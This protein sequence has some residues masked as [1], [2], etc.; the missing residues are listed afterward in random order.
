[1]TTNT[2]PPRVARQTVFHDAMRASFLE[3]PR[4]DLDAVPGAA[5]P[6]WPGIPG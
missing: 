2:S 6:A 5:T 3:L 1:V 4:I